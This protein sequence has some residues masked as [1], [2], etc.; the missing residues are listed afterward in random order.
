LALDRDSPEEVDDLTGELVSDN[1]NCDIYMN[2]MAGEKFK[3][4]MRPS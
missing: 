1:Q 4:D 2:C 3:R